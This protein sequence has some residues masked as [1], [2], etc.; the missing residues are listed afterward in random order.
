MQQVNPYRN[1][2]ATLRKHIFRDGRKWKKFFPQLLLYSLEGPGIQQPVL[3]KT[4]YI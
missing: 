3:L 4:K 1:V 2:L